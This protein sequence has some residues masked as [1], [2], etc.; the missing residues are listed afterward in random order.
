MQVVPQPIIV[1]DPV[2]ALDEIAVPPLSNWSST[3]TSAGGL[4]CDS[5]PADLLSEVGAAH[6][7]VSAGLG[8]SNCGY[9]EGPEAESLPTTTQLF[10]ESGSELERAQSG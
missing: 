1:P 9:T 6:Q 3:I 2:K 5:P 4:A 7:E 8:S 10:R